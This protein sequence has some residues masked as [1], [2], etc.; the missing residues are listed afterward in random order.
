[1]LQPLKPG[2][3]E[4]PQGETPWQWEACTQPERS[5]RP[6]QLRKPAHSK[7]DPAPTGVSKRINK[8]MQL[9]RKQRSIKGC[10]DWSC[11]ECFWVFTILFCY[12]KDKFQLLRS[13]RDIASFLHGALHFFFF[14][15]LFYFLCLILGT[16]HMGMIS[17]AFNSLNRKTILLLTLHLKSLDY[18]LLF[19]FV[20]QY[21]QLIC[22]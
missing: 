7:E 16:T 18:F 17:S 14:F 6:P 19:W 15:F 1:M 21:Y 11:N 10:Q 5:P 4:P 13:D 22:N 8:I 9:W 3:L 12:L 20:T 2:A